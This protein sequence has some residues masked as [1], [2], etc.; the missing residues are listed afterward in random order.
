MPLGEFLT[1]FIPFGAATSAHMD[2]GLHR[3][4]VGGALRANAVERTPR[5][6]LIHDRPGPSLRRT[7]H[8]A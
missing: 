1:N 6:R 4:A 2:S 5:R 8:A 3:F 7:S